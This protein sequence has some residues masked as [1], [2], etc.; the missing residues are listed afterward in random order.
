MENAINA[1]PVIVNTIA[2]ISPKV[3][4]YETYF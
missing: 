4:Y 1:M 3:N 2:N